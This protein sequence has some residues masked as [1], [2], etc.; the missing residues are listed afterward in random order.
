MV[1][2]DSSVWVA[3]DRRR[4][5]LSELIPRDE[6]VACCPIVLTEVMRGTRLE[7]Y[8]VTRA[9]LSNA[10]MLDAPTPLR[11]FEEAALI[12][13]RCRAKGVTPSTP[14]C[15]IAACA[16]AN[17]V[18]LLHD[19]SDFNQIARFTRLPLFTRSGA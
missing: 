19:D 6:E 7:R 15:L 3:I 8:T 11:R 2:L 18:P 10:T 13:L 12:Y 14:D 17:G 16:I 4:L 9:M 1:L 5:S